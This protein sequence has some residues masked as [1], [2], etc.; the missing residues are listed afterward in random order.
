MLNKL[1]RR[2]KLYI[3]LGGVGLV[4]MV[5]VI[6]RSEMFHG[7]KPKE[8]TPLVDKLPEDAEYT[9]EDVTAY[10]RAPG[11]INE[12]PNHINQWYLQDGGTSIMVSTDFDDQPP[13]HCFLL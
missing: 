8:G 9:L 3:I 11:S 5:F 12:T 1:D 4:S 7:T 2:T 13:N 10:H 6:S